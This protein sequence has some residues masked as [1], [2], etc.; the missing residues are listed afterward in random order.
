MALLQGGDACKF[1]NS[2][3]L[4]ID[5]VSD[6][7]LDGNV[8]IVNAVKGANGFWAQ[9]VGTQWQNIDAKVNKFTI[10]STDCDASQTVCVLIW[11]G[12]KMIAK[13][14]DAKEIE[15]TVTTVQKSNPFAFMMGQASS[16][17]TEIKKVKVEGFCQVEGTVVP[18][19]P[20]CDPVDCYPNAECNGG[21]CHCKS[22]FIAYNSALT[23]PSKTL[24]C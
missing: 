9:L 22:G 2:K 16:T 21:Q 24:L 17:S 19:G 18:T 5:I 14:Y 11:D 10:D 1:A 13:M 3:P 15:I 6:L 7:K 12:T 23:I 4:S 20:Q 8:A